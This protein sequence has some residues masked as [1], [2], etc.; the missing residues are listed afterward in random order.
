MRERIR[1]SRQEKRSDPELTQGQLSRRNFLKQATSIGTPALLGGLL[2][3]SI[4]EGFYR[5]VDFTAWSSDRTRRMRFE[6]FGGLSPKEREQIIAAEVQQARSFLRSQEGKRILESGTDD[7]IF[8]LLTSLPTLLREHIAGTS[9]D[10]PKEKWPSVA[11][12]IT[13]RGMPYVLGLNNSPKTI[14]GKYHGNGVFVAPDTMLTNWH[15]IAKQNEQDLAVSSPLAAQESSRLQNLYKSKNIDAVYIHFRG[16]VTLES[17]TST[18][19]VLPFSSAISDA[20]VSGNLITVAGIDP[21]KSAASDGTKI[22]PSIAVPVTKRIHTFLEHYAGCGK[23]NFV[24]NG[25]V[26]IA[27]PG[28]SAPRPFP[29][30]SGSRLLD[31]LQDRDPDARMNLMQGTSGS[32]VLMNGKLV[33]INHRRGDIEYKG[34]GLDVGFFHGPDALRKAREYGMESHSRE[35]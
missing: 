14:A 1:G 15:V 29:S 19:T 3:G 8:S 4:V 6:R 28:E 16:P 10:I 13:S 34:L 5:L 31:V 18:P 17:S 33:G 22:Y 30:P 20:D 23:E 26:Y 35:P 27:P 12:G 2:G 11:V 32:P 25:F 24:E 9:Y 21:D 7:E